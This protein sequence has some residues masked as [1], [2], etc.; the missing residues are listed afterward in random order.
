METLVYIL[1][2]FIILGLFYYSKL[3]PY[4]DK[5]DGNY[6]KLYDAIGRILTPLLNLIGK[7]IKP[8]RVGS[9]IYVDV[10]QFALL[11]ILLLS[12]KFAL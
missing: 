9:G 3:T 4:K 11:L 12:L 1:I 5:L 2:C 7:I 10:S 8:T 6:R